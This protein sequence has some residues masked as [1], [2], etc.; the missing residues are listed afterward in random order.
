MYYLLSVCPKCH[1]LLFMKRAANNF[2]TTA[3]TDLII[4]VRLSHT[5]EKQQQHLQQFESK[6]KQRLL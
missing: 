3:T 2:K 4:K 5:G 6:T 1:S